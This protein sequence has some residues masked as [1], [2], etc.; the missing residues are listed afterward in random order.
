MLTQK[1]ANINVTVTRD[2]C[3]TESWIENPN[4][5]DHDG[6]ALFKFLPRHYNNKKQSSVP[7]FQELVG[8][9]WLGL[10]F[11]AMGEM[12]TLLKLTGGC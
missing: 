10:T 9:D 6:E 8:K 11:V 5:D 4:G 1:G 3:T 7:I 2:L 12:A